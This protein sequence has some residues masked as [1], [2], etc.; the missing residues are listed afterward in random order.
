VAEDISATA[1]GAQAAAQVSGLAQYFSSCWSVICWDSSDE[2][3]LR[4]RARCREIGDTTEITGHVREVGNVA[5]ARRQEMSV[6]IDNALAPMS[7]H[8]TKVFLADFMDGG[9]VW[10][11]VGFLLAIVVFAKVAM[12]AAPVQHTAHRPKPHTGWSLEGPKSTIAES[13]AEAMLE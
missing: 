5:A 1:G 2:S 3:N 8:D 10:F 13:P 6:R 4:P 12:E 7:W 11:F 9:A